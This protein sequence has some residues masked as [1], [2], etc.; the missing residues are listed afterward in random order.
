MGN[1]LHFMLNGAHLFVQKGTGPEECHHCSARKPTHLG[2]LPDDQKENPTPPQ[3]HYE[4]SQRRLCD[5]PASEYPQLV[6]W[7]QEG[8]EA[9]SEDKVARL[10]AMCT[11]PDSKF[12]RNQCLRM[13]TKGNYSDRCNNTINRDGLCTIHHP[14]YVHPQR[15]KGWKEAKETGLDT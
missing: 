2:E 15:E 13:W 1:C 3:G 11:V 12:H 6:E 7:L 4:G 14:D 5:I 10:R 8:L 9:A